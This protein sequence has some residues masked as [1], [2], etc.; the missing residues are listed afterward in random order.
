MKGINL[1]MDRKRGWRQMG[2]GG[3]K[4]RDRQTETMGKP[5]KVQSVVSGSQD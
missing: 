5:N 2:G 3:C 1:G 4:K